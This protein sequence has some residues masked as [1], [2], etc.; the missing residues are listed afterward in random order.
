MASLKLYIG[1]YIVDLYRIS[2][3]NIRNDNTFGENMINDS[4]T[5]LPMLTR[6]GDGVFS[7]QSDETA[8]INIK[9]LNTSSTRRI[10]EVH[11]V[12]T[13]DWVYDATGDTL[14]DILTISPKMSVTTGVFN[15]HPLTNI[16]LR[17]SNANMSWC[18]HYLPYERLYYSVSGELYI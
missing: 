4:D 6:R 5:K 15:I 11:I 18:S 14:Y 2:M 9:I 16:F 8:A 10:I 12:P 17:D 3:Y 13:G 1:K 7:A